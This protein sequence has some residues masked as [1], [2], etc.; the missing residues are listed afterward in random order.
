ML[1]NTVKGAIALEAKQFIDATGDGHLAMLSGVPFE[2]G[3]E[4]D[5]AIQPYTMMFF[6]GGVDFDVIK[7]Y[8]RRGMWQTG[9]I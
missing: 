8:N 4:G 3:R 1:L 6:V 2:I 7:E 5:G 9:R